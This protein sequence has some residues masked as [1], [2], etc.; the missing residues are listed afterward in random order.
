MDSIKTRIR[1][2]VLFGIWFTSQ[3]HSQRIGLRQLHG[4]PNKV[5]EIGKAAGGNTETDYSHESKGKPS[6]W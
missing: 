4:A 6:V 1:C 3:P 5:E 2:V